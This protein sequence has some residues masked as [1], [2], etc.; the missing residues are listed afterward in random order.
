MKSIKVKNI[1]EADFSVYGRCADLLHPDTPYIGKSPVQFYRDML[2]LSGNET[3]S[4]SVTF[5]E[6]VPMVATVMEYHSVAGE[7]FLTLDSD[8]FICVAPASAGERLE[9]DK[10]EGFFVPKGTAVYIHPGVWHYAPFPAGDKSIH[11]LVM[12]PQRTYANDCRKYTLTP[13]EQV[14]LD[15]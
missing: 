3:L 13:E 6:P 10:M 14:R 1:L 9:A 2:P 12:L 5:A 4:L 8:T 7:C 15:V 11:S